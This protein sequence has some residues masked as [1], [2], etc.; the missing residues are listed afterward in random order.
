MQTFLPSKDF[1]TTANILD[2]K[3]LNKQILESY[4]ILKVLSNNDPKAGWRNHPAVK[5]WRGHEHGLFTYALA[6]VREANRRNIKTDK[7]ME[8][9]VGLRVA[10]LSRWGHGMPAWYQN[11]EEMQKITT[12][13]RAR[14]FV[15]DSD[16]YNGFGIF[17]DHPNNTPCCDKCQYY[18]P[19]H[20]SE[21][22]VSA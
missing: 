10:N 1:D 15:K 2:S 18:W 16:F 14:L 17:L 5:M 7:N 13:H 4:Q 6:M 19:T 20:V 9:L 21:R 12:T 8:N 11:S 3:R 22:K